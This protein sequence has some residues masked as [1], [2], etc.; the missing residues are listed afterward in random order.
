MQ[1]K[2]E[3]I[4]DEAERLKHVQRW[5]SKCKGPEVKYKL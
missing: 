1:D 4:N 3:H 2:K 5:Q